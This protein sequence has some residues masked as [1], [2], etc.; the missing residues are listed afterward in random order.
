MSTMIDNVTDRARGLYESLPSRQTVGARVRSGLVRAKA[1]ASRVF[2]AVKARVFTVSAAVRAKVV[3]VRA[4]VALRHATPEG[5]VAST[6]PSWNWGAAFAPVA[7]LA[8]PGF[9]RR[10]ARAGGDFFR[11]GVRAG[12]AAAAKAHRAVHTRIS[13]A[14][15]DG[16]VRKVLK[17]FGLILAGAHAFVVAITV[18]VVDNLVSSYTDSWT[19]AAVVWTA[20]VMV[21]VALVA[22]TFGAGILLSVPGVGKGLYADATRPFEALRTVLSV[23]S[24][25]AMASRMR[26]SVTRS[27]ATLARGEDTLASAKATYIDL[28]T[29]GAADD[30]PAEPAEPAEPAPMPV[31]EFTRT[32]R[33]GERF[34]LIAEV[35]G[36]PALFEVKPARRKKLNVTCDV[37]IP[38]EHWDAVTALVMDQ[39]AAHEARRVGPQA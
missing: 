35:D 14:V 8:A 28:S 4:R 29:A 1:L 24:L 30:A 23:G 19:E 34:R 33:V 5:V 27:E 17:G 37:D 38:G 7:M 21:L 12:A 2:A 18:S 15:P 25:A 36:I 31:V 6:A 10:T 39:V 13:R 3:I 11:Q 16:R 32:V 26:D 22:W 20:R 9:Y